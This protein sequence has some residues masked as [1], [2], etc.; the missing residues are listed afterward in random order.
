M[1]YQK[2]AMLCFYVSV[3]NM[4]V[5]NMTAVNISCK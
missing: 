2:G 3:K 1:G 5:K 4:T